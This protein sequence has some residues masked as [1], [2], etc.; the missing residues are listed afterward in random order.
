MAETISQISE[1]T[2]LLAL[3]AAIEA[4]RAGESGKGFAVVA[5][6]VRK[7]AEQSSTAVNNVKETTDKV[8][9]AFYNIS[10][11]SSDLLSFMNEKIGN[12][13]KEFINVG[14]EYKKDGQFINEMSEEL[15]SMTE[16]I[17]ATIGQITQ[18]VQNVAEIS[19]NSSE[20]SNTM[21]ENIENSTSSI[22]YIAKSANEQS[23]QIEQL[24]EII[25]K[26][27]M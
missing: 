6:E 19:Q 13:F 5:E 24:D 23:K 8:S 11:S 18:A 4:A 27:K 2:N 14:A 17:L 3:N 15:A 21:Q 1:Q 9:E 20:H 26:F 16:E 7:L 10:K 25:S 22:K 12:Q